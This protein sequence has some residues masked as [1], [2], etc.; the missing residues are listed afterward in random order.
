VG[1]PNKVPDELLHGSAVALELGAHALVVGAQKRLDVLGI[2]RLGAC[3]EADEVAE[4][5]RDDLALA[6]L[7]AA[8][9]GVRDYG[10]IA[11]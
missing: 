2:H 8:C 6:A 4:H 11:E 1:A 10:V 5:D 7:G 3:R 9:H